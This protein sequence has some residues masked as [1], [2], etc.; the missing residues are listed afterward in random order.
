MRCAATCL[1]LLLC[2][3]VFADGEGMIIRVS[4]LITP[5]TPEATV[6]VWA[7][8]DPADYAFA[9]ARLEAVAGEAGWAAPELVLGAP[10]QTAGS[11]TPDG[12]RVADIAV[13]QL[14]L[15][16]PGPVAD[17]DNPILIWRAT[18]APALTPARVI[19]VETRTSEFYTYPH[20][21]PAPP[22]SRYGDAFVDGSAIVRVGACY[23]D[24][25]ASD[26]LDL[27]DFLCFQN[28]FA[29]GDPYADC[30][31]NGAL[32]LFDFLCFQTE[33]AAGCP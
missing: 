9:A 28:A 23:A 14:H 15:L 26:G 21:D 20:R 2:V 27:F 1:T 12:K 17:P 31:G 13:G 6:E 7:V 8:F 32:D 3:P 25:D 11:V 29:T 18:F 10:G 33:F 16:Y 5:Q 22:I 24:C 4:N 19:D 30:D